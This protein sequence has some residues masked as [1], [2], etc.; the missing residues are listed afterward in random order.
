MLLVVVRCSYSCRNGNGNGMSES[1]RSVKGGN[2]NGDSDSDK[3]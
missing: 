2:D 3:Y 1:D